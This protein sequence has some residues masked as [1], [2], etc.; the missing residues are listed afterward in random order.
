[1]TPLID[2]TFLLLITFII[3]FPMI[4]QGVKIQ[5]P[6]GKAEELK[7]AK[8]VTL[9]LSYDGGLFLDGKKIFEEELPRHLEPVAKDPAP[10]PLLVRC[11]ERIDYG[12]L[13]GILR[14]LKATGITRMA[15][16]TEP[17]D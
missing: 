9:S 11:D 3:A 14:I 17:S 12:R 10:P 16:V 7:D 2:L 4:E 8:S 1:M 5:L 15:L 13:M 6:K